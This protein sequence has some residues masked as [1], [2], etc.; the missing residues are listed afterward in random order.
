MNLFNYLPIYLPGQI[1][2]WKILLHCLEGSISDQKK[3]KPNQNKSKQ[4]KKM[5]EIWDLQV[6]ENVF[7][8]NHDNLREVYL[9]F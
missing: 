3:T 1:H 2:L 7:S 9:D 4:N 6:T 5:F 8:G